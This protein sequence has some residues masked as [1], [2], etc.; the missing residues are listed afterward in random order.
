MSLFLVPFPWC[1][2]WCQGT[3]AASRTTTAAAAVQSP[4]TWSNAEQRR[5][6]E[7]SASLAAVAVAMPCCCKASDDA[8]GPSPDATDATAKHSEPGTETQP[9]FT[10]TESND[11]LE[12]Q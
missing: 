8:D 2:F 12:T 6:T 9:S 4:E 3:A 11:S 10:E 1:P 7:S 5:A